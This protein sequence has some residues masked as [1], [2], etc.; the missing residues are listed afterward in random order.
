MKKSKKRKK[1]NIGQIFVALFWILFIFALVAFTIIY[2][3]NA[4]YSGNYLDD[5]AKSMRW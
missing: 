2:D 1:I 4:Q 5:V 3:P